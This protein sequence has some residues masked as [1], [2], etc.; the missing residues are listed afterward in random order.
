MSHVAR[1]AAPP[2]RLRK[3]RINTALD[4]FFIL[5]SPVDLK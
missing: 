2:A 5:D 1:N 4:M 3:A